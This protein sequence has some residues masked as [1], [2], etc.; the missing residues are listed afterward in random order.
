MLS[1]QYQNILRT[2]TQLSDLLSTL[3]EKQYSLEIAAL[4]GASIGKHVRHC[5]DVLENLIS[6]MAESEVSYDDRKRN[7]L[8]ET[9]PLAAREKIFELVGKLESIDENRMFSL[10]YLLDPETGLE[11]RTFSNLRREYQYVHDHTIHHMAIIKIYAEHFLRNVSIPDEFG[12]A[13]STLRFQKHPTRN[14][15]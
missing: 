4:K 3:E 8:Y 14:E 7:T 15:G 10:R 2:F 11:G 6:G 1:I 12:T 9:S 13:L 5:I